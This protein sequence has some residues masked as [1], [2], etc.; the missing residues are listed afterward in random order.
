MNLFTLNKWKNEVC[1]SWPTCRM[2]AQILM[3]G[4]DEGLGGGGGKSSRWAAA[5]PRCPPALLASAPETGEKSSPACSGEYKSCHHRQVPNAAHM[6]LPQR[7]G[8]SPWIKRPEPCQSSSH[9]QGQGLARGSRED[10]HLQARPP[11]LSKYTLFV[12]PLTAAAELHIG[13]RYLCLSIPLLAHS[14]LSLFA[15]P[16]LEASFALITS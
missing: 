3:R 15:H 12:I 7:D 11:D 1:K 5:S 16:H 14:S 8:N 10:F 13:P 4:W 2:A 9:S 6:Q